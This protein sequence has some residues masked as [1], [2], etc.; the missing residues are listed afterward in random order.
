MIAKVSG[1]NLTDDRWNV[2]TAKTGSPVL[3][4]TVGNARRA[5]PLSLRVKRLFRD[6]LWG[7]IP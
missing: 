7:M 4:T 6:W 1:I 3:G 2:E 5:G